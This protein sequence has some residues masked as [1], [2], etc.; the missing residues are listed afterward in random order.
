M[1]VSI[2]TAHRMVRHGII[3]GRQVCRGAAWAIKAE[4]VAAHCAQR[5]SQRP[6]TA[7]P[8]QHRFDFQ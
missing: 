4:D 2:M 1:D 3:K 6:L 7:D 8:S 5:S